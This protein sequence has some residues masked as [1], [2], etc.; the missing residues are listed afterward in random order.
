MKSTILTIPL[1][2][3]RLYED[4]LTLTSIHPPRNY[5]NLDSLS[6][7]AG[8]I[9]H[10]LNKLSCE[11]HYQ[12]FLADGREYKNVI[13]TF[14][15]V[16]RERVVIGAHY[17]VCGNQPGADDNASAVAGLLELARI[18]DELQPKLNYDL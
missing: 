15:D 5:L 12:K 10:E 16:S 8:Y 17:D 1:Q 3:A 14:G 4:V 2:I 13:A 18:V 11:V 7:I 9:A 6:A